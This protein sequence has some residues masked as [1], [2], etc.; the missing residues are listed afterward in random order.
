M[1][2]NR[3]PQLPKQCKACQYGNR[4]V[5]AYACEVCAVTMKRDRKAETRMRREGEK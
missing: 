1:K 3:G 5:E 2:R 4:P